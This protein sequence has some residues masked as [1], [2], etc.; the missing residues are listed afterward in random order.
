M[1]FI[2]AL[3]IGQGFQQPYD[4]DGM[5]MMGDDDELR[6]PSAEPFPRGDQPDEQ[7][8]DQPGA[9]DSP[10]NAPPQSNSTETA[11]ASERRARPG[12]RIHMD[13]ETGLQNRHLVDWNTNYLENMLKMSQTKQQKRAAT[14][15]K[16]NAAFW[17]LGQGIG[18]VQATFGEDREPHPLAIFSGQA[19]LDALTGPNEQRSPPGSKRARSPSSDDEDE[20]RVRAR[21]AEGEEGRGLMDDGQLAIHDDDGIMM[22]GDDLNLESEIGRPAG[23]S[24]P[25][26]ASILPWNR[27]ASRQGSAQP[28]PSAGFGISSSVGGPGSGMKFGP[29][30]ILGGMRSRLPSSSPLV[31]KGH[32]IMDL[33]DLQE[34]AGRGI[35]LDDDAGIMAMDDFEQYGPSAAVDTQTAAQSQWMRATLENEAQNFLGF[36]EAQLVEQGEGGVPADMVTLDELLPPEENSGI[37]AAQALLH[38]LALTTKGLLEVEQEDAFGDILLKVVRIGNQAY[39]PGGRVGESSSPEQEEVL[40]GSQLADNNDDEDEEQEDEED[41]EL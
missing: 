31:G 29:G 21:T 4:D 5:M 13:Q 14:Q 12:K 26:V 28:F 36:I 32:P 38:V 27:S 22:Q 11:E 16:K 33:D 17:I 9:Q 20:R 30:H 8:I 23:S 40:H 34:L 18:G 7:Q 41:D 25:D 10:I 15:G 3:T 19:L 2:A 24:I 6:L 37:V 39:G 1:I 35:G